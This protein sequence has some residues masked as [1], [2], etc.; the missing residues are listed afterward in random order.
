VPCTDCNSGNVIIRKVEI[1]VIATVQAV[2]FWPTF[3]PETLL[4][5]VLSHLKIEPYTNDECL[6]I[7]LKIYVTSYETYLTYYN[8]ISWNT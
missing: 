5:T 6:R 8:I 2:I 3:I 7:H 1:V 4:S